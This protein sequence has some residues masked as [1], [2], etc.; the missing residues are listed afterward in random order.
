LAQANGRWFAVD[1][2]PNAKGRTFF[3]EQRAEGERQMA[4]GAARAA[5]MPE[6][7]RTEIKQLLAQNHWTAAIDRYREA[8]GA[9]LRTA[10]IVINAMAVKK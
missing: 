10:A 5:E 6:S 4:E 1:P 8:T 3:A 9:D 7:L 2:C